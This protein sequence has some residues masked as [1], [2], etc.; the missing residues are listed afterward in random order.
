[1]TT[2]IQPWSKASARSGPFWPA[3]NFIETA[4]F[5]M[6]KREQIEPSNESRAAS[7]TEMERCI[8]GESG[9]LREVLRQLAIV[10]P[11]DSTVL[12]LGETGTGKELIA[13]AIHNRSPRRDRP[14]IKVN[15]AAIPAGL[16]ESELFGHERGAFTG[17][18]SRRIGRFEMA[19]TGTLFLDEIGDIPHELQ[20]K[21]LR[22]LQEQEFE[23]VGG[24]QA[25]RV[26]ARIVT[27]TSRDLPR[28]VAAREFR[29]DLYYRLNVFPLRVPALR[30][31]SEDIPLL[32]RH[33]VG[34]YAR[35]MN[36]CI[37]IIPPATIEALSRYTWPGNIRELQNVIERA[38]ILSQDRVLHCPLAELRTS[39]AEPTAF[40]RN[41]Y[42]NAKTLKDSQREHILQAL[43]ETNWVIGGPRGAAAQL[44][45]QRTT[46]SAMMQR[47]GI[48][49]IQA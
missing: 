19:D 18:L 12:I 48:C 33:F 7:G 23:R 42:S 30:E 3:E 31:R 17:A 5:G 1:M 25:T 49:R 21:L 8:I 32:V 13:R 29:A 46:L 10:A 35:K 26:D 11:M 39:A 4:R 2:L 6:P 16:I 27:A 38:V 40:D 43:A 15:C 41:D 22:V 34:L 37:T 44:G 36:R 14:F 20:P 45:L 24:T 28:M 9:A 47:L